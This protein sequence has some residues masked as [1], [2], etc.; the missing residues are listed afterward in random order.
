MIT[1]QIQHVHLIQWGI[2]VYENSQ[3]L[4]PQCIVGRGFWVPS[5]FSFLSGLYGTSLHFTHVGS[6]CVRSDDGLKF[7][8]KISAP[9]T[10]SRNFLAAVGKLEKKALPV[11]RASNGNVSVTGPSTAGLKSNIEDMVEDQRRDPTFGL[12]CVG[13]CG[14]TPIIMMFT[15]A[16]KSYRYSINKSQNWTTFHMRGCEVNQSAHTTEQAPTWLFS[17]Y[18]YRTLPDWSLFSWVKLWWAGQQKTWSKSV[19]LFILYNCA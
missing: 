18:Y 8:A 17:L 9:E 15:F 19:V 5:C 7:P 2:P 11:W 1:L 16:V 6:V 4:L 14:N 13:M 3:I 12:T 10:R